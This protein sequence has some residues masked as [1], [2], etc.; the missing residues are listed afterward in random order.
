MRPGQKRIHF[1]DE[2][3]AERRRL[4]DGFGR[5]P[6]QLVLVTAR[7]SHGSNSERARQ[8]CLAELVTRLQTDSVPRLVLESRGDDRMDA[9]TIIRARA[10]EP[11]FVFEHRRP[12]GE[13]LLW[14]ADGLAWAGAVRGSDLDRVAAILRTDIEVFP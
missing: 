9:R 12:E 8:A 7:V 2:S 4:L 11:V 1:H 6:V 3:N 14:L 5:L 10:A 13:A